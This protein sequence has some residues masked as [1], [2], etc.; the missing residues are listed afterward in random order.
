MR[1]PPFASGLLSILILGSCGGNPGRPS[2]VRE[3]VAVEPA[4]LPLPPPTG[5]VGDRW[6]LTTVFTA[7][8]G[9]D[10]CFS[11]E[12]R[13]RLG[14]ATAWTMAVSRSGSRVSFDYDVHNWPTDDLL[15]YGTVSGRD[16]T[17]S[18]TAQA[19]SSPPCPD[20]TVLSGTFIASVSGQFSEDGNH[21]EGHQSSVYSFSTGAITLHESWSADK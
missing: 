11:Q 14:Q 17:A 13:S 7:V 8:D 10:N 16:F 1:T 3:P 2:P 15:E 5:P 21:L 19:S 9:P 20:G 12:L 4:H 6:H 18:S